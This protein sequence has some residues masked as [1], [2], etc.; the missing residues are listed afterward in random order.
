MESEVASKA[1]ARV[2]MQ[3]LVNEAWKR[4]PGLNLFG[5]D[6]D[7]RSGS[8]TLPLPI[9]SWDGSSDLLSFSSFSK[10]ISSIGSSGS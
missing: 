5:G 6:E 1:T 9:P 8:V 4:H 2:I 10:I 3:R 7:A